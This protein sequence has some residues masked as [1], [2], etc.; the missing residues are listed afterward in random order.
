MRR[1]RI[2][3]SAAVALALVLAMPALA[4]QNPRPVRPGAAIPA[5]NLAWSSLNPGQQAALAPLANLWP[6]LGIDQ[7][8]K[9]LA[10]AG[11]YQ[12]LPPGEQATL[13]RR[14]ADWATL[15]PEQRTR[16]RLNFGEA[17]KLPA[18][19][20]R[21]KWEEYQTLP[22]A[23]RERLVRDRPSPPVTTAPALRPAPP[24]ARIARPPSPPRH[25]TPG[26]V[27]DSDPD[28]LLNRNTLLPQ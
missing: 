26:T 12:Q 16:V 8:R 22:Q 21:A 4:Q 20:R 1:P 15:A 28:A 24:P 6:T 9:W 10:L 19:E 2:R 18:D 14:M 23:E 7:Q 27:R 3:P 11:D 5:S 25:G 13:Q 17:R